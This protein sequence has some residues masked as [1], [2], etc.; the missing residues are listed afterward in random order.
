ML[1]S[2]NPRHCRVPVGNLSHDGCTYDMRSSN[3]KRKMVLLVCVG[4]KPNCFLVGE[5]D[6][7]RYLDSHISS[8]CRISDEMSLG[9]RTT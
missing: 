7:S 2:A 9:V 8:G 4:P 3:S 1:L 6:K 5:V